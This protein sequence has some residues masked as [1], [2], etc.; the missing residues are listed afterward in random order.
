MEL[1]N[2]KKLTEKECTNITMM[3]MMGSKKMKLNKC[4]TNV[5]E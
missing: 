4:D 2:L 1:E 5:T 3:I